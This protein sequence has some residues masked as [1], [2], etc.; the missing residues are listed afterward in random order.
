MKVWPLR[1]IFDTVHLATLMGYNDELEQHALM[2]VNGLQSE[3]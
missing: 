2:Y 1:P 3:L